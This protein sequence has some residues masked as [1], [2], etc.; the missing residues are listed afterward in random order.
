MIDV[1]TFG[2]PGNFA[3][4]FYNT[5]TQ[6]YDMPGLR[7]YLRGQLPAD[8][9]SF[10]DTQLDDLISGKGLQGTIDMYDLQAGEGGS[11]QG[12]GQGD[13]QGGDR[14]WHADR[15]CD[16]AGTARGVLCSTS[17]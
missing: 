4:P 2:I 6:Q 5:G 16:R 7:K 15:P 9:Y 14:V 8:R 3:I 13:G 10:T 17:V 12:D 11:F 1:G